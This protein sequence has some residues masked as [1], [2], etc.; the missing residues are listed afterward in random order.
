MIW[1]KFNDSKK[2]YAVEGHRTSNNIVTLIGDIPHN[3]SGFQTYTYATKMHI[4]DFSEY[5][6]IYK[7]LD[8]GVQFSNDGSKWI[9]P[10]PIKPTKPTTAW[11]DE[12]EAQVM[13][14]ALMT[15]TL[16]EEDY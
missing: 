5:K 8:N 2:R 12:I 7:T 1:V 4:G 11:S 15:D 16:L 6:T 3:E 10:E 14:T 13:W 9:E